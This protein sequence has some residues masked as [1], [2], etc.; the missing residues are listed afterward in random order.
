MPDLDR[1]V[2]IKVA[3]GRGTVGAEI[4]L[5]GHASGHWRELFGELASKRMRELNV[6]AE[7][8]EDHTGSSSGCLPRPDFHSGADAGCRKRSDQRGQWPGAA[9]SVRRHPNRG[10]YPQLVGAAAT[11]AASPPFVLTR[12]LG[13]HF[14][15]RASL[16][17][18][19]SEVI[20]SAF[21]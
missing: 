9:V 2:D 5:A 12:C 18:S 1:P 11:V 20:S 19:R 17:T 21:E 8:R 7:E 15:V 3:A 16:D 10:R 14:T 13:V 4:P 6:E